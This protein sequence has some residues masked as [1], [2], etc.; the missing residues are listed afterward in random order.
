MGVPA[1]IGKNGVEEVIEYVLS[2][3]ER[4]IF[5]KSVGLISNSVKIISEQK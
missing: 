3:E 1:V 4:E 5:E 2:Q